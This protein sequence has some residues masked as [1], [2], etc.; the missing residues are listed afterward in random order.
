MKLREW[1]VKNNIAPSTAYQWFH[2]GI[3]PVAATQLPTGTILIDQSL[4]SSPDTPMQTVVYARVSSHEQRDD[5]ERQVG[6]VVACVTKAGGSVDKTVCE[7]GS[8]LNGARPKLKKLLADSSVQT[9]CVEHRDRLGR[10][11]TEY[12]ESALS[13]QGRKISIVSE[14]EMQNDLV[15]DMVDV[16]TSFC[17]R[18]YGQRSAKLR[19]QRALVAAEGVDHG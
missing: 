3:L 16:L 13:A 18:L 2:A 12:L 5:L 10:F 7:I 8:G 14:G 4:T 1:A 9:I 15:Q 19:A 6:R 17:A 11:G